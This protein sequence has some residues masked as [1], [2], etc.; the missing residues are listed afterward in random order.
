MSFSKKNL[1]IIGIAILLLV[2]TVVLTSGGS[3]KTKTVATTI[4]VNNR[5]FDTKE[6]PPTP[7]LTPTP[8][9]KPTLTPTPKPTATPIPTNTP[10]PTAT[11]TLKPTPIKR[12]TPTPDLN[13]YA[14][15]I[16]LDATEITLQVDE[17]Y[18]IGYRIEPNETT[19]QTV[20]WSSSNG[21]IATATSDG[22]IVG[23]SKGETMIT[24]RTSNNKTATIKVVVEQIIPTPTAVLYP[25]R[26]DLSL[27]RLILK[28]GETKQLY[29]K[30]QPENI[31]DKTV[32]WSTNDSSIITVSGTGLVKGIKLGTA[33][34]EVESVNNLKGTAIVVVSN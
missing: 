27:S 25:S 14:T 31:E 30:Y 17:S 21:D 28:V 29:V 16:V 26:I 8:T 7:T 5:D 22:W 19:D 10:V 13:V 15:G 3:K 2:L 12:P 9:L 33:T 18:Q 34:I 6:E 1:I 20:Y 4:P 32:T 11:P 23:I 24:A